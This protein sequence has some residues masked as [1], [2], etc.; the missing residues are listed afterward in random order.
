M[1]LFI[2]PGELKKQDAASPDWLKKLMNAW[3]DGLNFYLSRHSE[4]KPRVIQ[5]FE[6]I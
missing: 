2:S 1:K 3:S 4:V 5:R 6:P